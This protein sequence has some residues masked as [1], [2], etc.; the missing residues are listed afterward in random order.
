MDEELAFGPDLRIRTS[1]DQ[2]SA[3]LDGEVAILNSKSGVYYGLDPV[4]TRVWELLAETRTF[5]ELCGLM[6]A[7]FDVAED[8][9]RQ[10]LTNL[11]G[12]L[13]RNGLVEVVS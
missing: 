3:D 12:D 7:E 5:S 4:G 11:V 10:D 1:P 13:H 6:L 9:L 8:R 2:V